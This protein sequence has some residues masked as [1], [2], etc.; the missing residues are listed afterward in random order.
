LIAMPRNRH[1]KLRGRAR[2]SK[3]ALKTGGQL[4]VISPDPRAQAVGQGMLLASK[5]AGAIEVTAR[6]TKKGGIR[7]GAT[8]GA[9]Q[10]VKF[11]NE[12]QRSS[13]AA[14]KRGTRTR[15]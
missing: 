9:R 2:I 13:A 6:S 4:L 5:G 7:G 11:N 3:T 8:T 1:L 12:R 14:P 15:K 10:G